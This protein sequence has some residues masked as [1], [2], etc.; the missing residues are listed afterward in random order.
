MSSSKMH[1]RTWPRF[2]AS[3]QDNV[4]CCVTSRLGEE[5]SEAVLRLVP[6]H[7]SIFSQLAKNLAMMDE[8]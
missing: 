6:V 7:K 3:Y 8:P 5:R 2:E 4:V 1:H